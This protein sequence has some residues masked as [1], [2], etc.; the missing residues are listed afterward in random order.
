MMI[1][2]SFDPK[3]ARHAANI[4]VETQAMKKHLFSYSP[5]RHEE[6]HKTSC[7][8]CL[9]GEKTFIIVGANSRPDAQN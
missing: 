7:P 9:R 4:K 5:Q 8:S 1:G 3:R 2:K 6:K